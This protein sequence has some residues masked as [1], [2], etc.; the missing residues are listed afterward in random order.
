MSSI[1]CW[2]ISVILYL[3]S[4]PPSRSPSLLPPLSPSHSECEAKDLAFHMHKEFQLFPI[5]N[6]AESPFLSRPLPLREAVHV[7]KGQY[8]H[9]FV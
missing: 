5:G 7:C 4:L 8:K 1:L 6:N 2:C 3:L 9:V